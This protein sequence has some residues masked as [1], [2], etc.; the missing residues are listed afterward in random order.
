[1]TTTSMLEPVTLLGLGLMG[2][3]L[4]SALVSGGHPTLVWNRTSAKAD[5]LVRQGAQR[6][7]SAD[8]AVRASALVLVCVTDYEATTSVLEPLTKALSGR[9]V[10]N[11]T[12]GASDDA[13]SMS[14]WAAAHGIA[15]LDGAI[16]ADPASIGTEQALILVSGDSAVFEEHEQTLRRLGT[17]TF[18]GREPGLAALHDVALLGVMWGV[19]NAF[20]HGAALVGTAGVPARTLLPLAEG[21]V[22][23]TAGWL[24]DFAVQVDDASYPAPDATLATHLAAAEHLVRE[25]EVLGVDATLPLAQQASLARAVEAGQGSSGYAALIEQLRPSG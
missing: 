24:A 1:M 23:T 20:L 17:V 18:L 12:S 3:A 14:L 22:S 4:G 25:S 10:L 15:Y 11:L 16:M 7:T 13:R 2:E 9:A 21:I 6:C 19:L 5:S 8:E